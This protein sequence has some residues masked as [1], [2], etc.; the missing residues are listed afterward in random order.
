MTSCAEC[1]AG[2]N[3]ELGEG[4]GVKLASVDDHAGIGGASGAKG[5]TKESPEPLAALLL[6]SALLPLP[7]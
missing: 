3:G 7:V 5:E 2:R 6:P 4:D 1:I